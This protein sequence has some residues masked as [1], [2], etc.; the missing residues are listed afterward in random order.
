MSNDQP[1]CIEVICGG[2][3]SGKTEELIR[4]LRRIIIAQMKVQV[5]KPIIDTRYQSDRITSHIGTSLLA[6]PIEQALLIPYKIEA[7]TCVIA[8]DEVQF[9]EPIIV[10]VCNELAK[11]G[12]RIICA[13]LDM[14]FRG[15]AFE[16]T[17]RLMAIAEKVDKLHAIC[18]VCGADASLTQRLVNGDPASIN[19]PIIMLGADESYQARCRQCYEIKYS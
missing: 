9:F 13:G 16:T 14:D 4:R 2:M 5:F 18:S 3:F 7:E 19:D 8:I 15:E 10:E 12:K 11:Q 17:A 1:G 6:N